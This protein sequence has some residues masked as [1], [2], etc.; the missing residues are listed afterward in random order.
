MFTDQPTGSIAYLTGEYPKASH[1]FIQREVEA[2]RRL[3]LPVQTFSVRRPNPKDVLADQKT[4]EDQTYFVLEN[5]KRLGTLGRAHISKLFGAPRAYFRALGLTWRLRQ[6]GLRATLYQLFYFAEAVVLADE[7]ERRGVSHLHNHFGD[8][9]CTVAVLASVLSGIPYSFTEHGP[10]IFFDAARWRLD[11]KIARA[12]FVVAIS[13]FCRSQLMLFSSPEHWKKIAIVHCGVDPKRYRSD[14][15]RIPGKH[16]LYV[17][18]LEPVKGL[19]V[20]LEA[21]ANIRALHPD[22]QVTIVGDGTS[23]PGIEAE[24]KRLQLTE[25]ISFVGY[26]TQAEVADLLAVTDLLVL[27]SFAE[28]VPV[29]LMEAMASGKPVIASRVAG[30]Q[31]LV[32]DGVSG[33][34]VSPGDVVSLANRIDHLVRDR[35]LAER[36]GQAGR[37]IVEQGFDIDKEASKLARLFVQDSSHLGRAEVIP[38]PS[39]AQV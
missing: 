14:Q 36:M 16:V 4:E 32:Y 15:T 6:P 29:V 39:A 13:H 28:G 24:A 5:C 37:D 19:L 30:V 26:K 17:G 8:S 12:K 18:R 11:E 3:G 21:I 23:R 20:L 22:L 2:L 1:T 27:P 38:E 31:E 9:S 35:S 10:N 7:L 34:T 25:L 33:Y